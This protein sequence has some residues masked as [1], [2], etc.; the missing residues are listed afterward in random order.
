MYVYYLKNQLHDDHV[1]TATLRHRTLSYL[2]C[3]CICFLCSPVSSPLPPV[4]TAILS[5]VLFLLFVIF[6]PC[7]LQLTMY[8]L[9]L[10]TFKKIHGTIRS[11]LFCLII[12]SLRLSVEL[13]S[14]RWFMPLC[15][16]TT[17]YLYISLLMKILIV[18]ILFPFTNS[19]AINILK[20]VSWYTFAAV[21]LGYMFDNRTLGY[22]SVSKNML[23]M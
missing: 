8:Y 14:Y 19:A 23:G 21:S 1:P 5:F 15:E 6:T 10:P 22:M 2:R 4:V 7:A 11:V 9:V 18:S 13:C 3:H 16:Y 12:M 20:N 17:T